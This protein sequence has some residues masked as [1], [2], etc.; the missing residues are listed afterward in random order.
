MRIIQVRMSVD[1]KED[2]GFHL[3]SAH[4]K[5]YEYGNPILIPPENWNQ[6]EQ[7]ERGRGE[8]TARRNKRI[9]DVHALILD[10]HE[11]Q[12]KRFKEKTGPEPSAQTIKH[13]LVK[14][15]PPE[16]DI[17]SVRFQLVIPEKRQFGTLI[18]HAQVIIT[19]NSTADTGF[20][21]REAHPK[22][23]EHGA[24]IPFHFDHWNAQDERERGKGHDATKR[25]KRIVNVQKS[26]V[27]LYSAQIERHKAKLGPEPSPGTVRHEFLTGNPPLF[28]RGP[29]SGA[30]YGQ[31][32]LYRGM[33]LVTAYN[34]FKI[35]L[36]QTNITNSLH[37]DTLAKWGYGLKYLKRFCTEDFKAE[38]V[39]RGWAREYHSWLMKTGPMSGDSATRYVKRIDDVLEYLEDEDIIDRNRI[40][41]LDLP[42]DPTKEV[43]FL[44]EEQRRKFWGLHIPGDDT[45]N[46][47]VWWLGLM[48]LT[49]L[50][51]PDALLYV[52]DRERYE[53][54]GIGGRKIV[55]RRSKKPYNEAR[56]PILPELDALM[57]HV[58]E[59]TVI[60]DTI[61]EYTRAIAPMIGFPHRFTIKIARK[62]AGAIFLMKD[63]TIQAISRFL[64]HSSVTTTERY[65]V[66]I[67]SDYADKEMEQNLLRR[68][69]H[70]RND[71]DIDQQHV[72]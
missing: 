52:A 9:A 16:M 34:L 20:L 48:M 30:M 42:R 24:L 39:T 35:H 27:Q 3:R 13:E 51:Y 36:E 21:L 60:A 15:Q 23:Y 19:V 29:V 2:P 68:M 22:G 12:I 50:D 7:R 70:D 72:A 45:F 33:S 37:E 31:Q 55:I 61:N 17:F 43:H 62:T 64:G 10:I 49:G 6:K 71:D 14:G 65:Y 66:K 5:G 54:M 11:K 47:V 25:N 63:F 8:E 44:D 38:S 53:C 41:D 59:Q 56:I 69:R 67:T 57:L 58:P 1:G 28:E 40:K 26:L 46:T 4:P 32:Q 18:F